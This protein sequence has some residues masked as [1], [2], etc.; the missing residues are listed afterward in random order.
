MPFDDDHP[1][2]DTRLSDTPNGVHTHNHNRG[3]GTFY[4]VNG[5]Q[6]IYHCAHS[7]ALNAGHR[8]IV[9][10]ESNSRVY[11]DEER[12]CAGLNYG[13]EAEPYRT[14]AA[15]LSRI[16]RQV[17][18][19]SERFPYDSTIAIVCREAEELIPLV[20]CVGRSMYQIQHV[21]PGIF[22]HSFFSSVGSDAFRYT[23]S[24]KTA[25]KTLDEAMTPQHPPPVDSTCWWP[26]FSK[27]LRE[28]FRLCRIAMTHFLHTFISSSFFEI[29]N[30]KDVRIGELIANLSPTWDLHCPTVDT[31]WVREA[32]GLKWYSIPLGFCGTWKEFAMVI[33]QYCRNGPEMEYIHQGNW[34]IVDI[35]DNQTIDQTCF[36]SVLKPE[37]RFDIGI[38]VHLLSGTRRI[39]PQCGHQNLG[40]TTTNGWI[41][42]SNTDCNNSYR[43]VATSVRNAFNSRSTQP[44]SNSVTSHH[45]DASTRP[46]VAKKLWAKLPRAFL[47]MPKHNNRTPLLPT[48]KESEPTKSNLVKQTKKGPYLN[49]K[50]HRILANTPHSPVEV[51]SAETHLV[52]VSVKERIMQGRA[53]EVAL[54]TKS[55]Q[56]LFLCFSVFSE[57][58]K[59]AGWVKIMKGLSPKEKAY[60]EVPY[61]VVSYLKLLESSLKIS[62]AGLLTTKTAIS[63]LETP[64]RSPVQLLAELRSHADRGR[65]EARRMEG[66]FRNESFTHPGTKMNG[67]LWTWGIGCVIWTMQTSLMCAPILRTVAEFIVGTVGMAI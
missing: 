48:Q 10:E 44:I 67:S 34:A 45:T 42:C 66:V 30:I 46:S 26:L 3:D 13:K 57:K 25:E 15:S 41:H 31:I 11:H 58:H 16:R 28:R 33:N 52:V 35:A 7:V 50:F 23:A 51:R 63:L 4:Q 40:N 20:Q 14:I 27:D 12:T 47:R 8:G 19:F 22:A 18:S 61:Q 60:K 54:L 6:N 39:C 17:L 29:I 65:L 1:R 38:I 56:E 2:D 62:S 59:R 9:G 5:T 21:Y 32:A 55:N 24:L 36:T 37:M 64:T 53:E 43:I 49:T